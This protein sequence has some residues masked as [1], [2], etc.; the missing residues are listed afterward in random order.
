[1]F[2]CVATEFLIILQIDAEDV[3]AQQD[4]TFIRMLL[5]KATCGVVAQKSVQET[6]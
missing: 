1:M 2:I 5:T 6:Q 4:K 3:R